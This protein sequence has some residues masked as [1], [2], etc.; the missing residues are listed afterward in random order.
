MSAH[1]VN[2]P[3]GSGGGNNSSRDVESLLA[4]FHDDD[5]FKYRA[6]TYTYLLLFPVSFVCNIGALVVFF[7]QSSRRS[8]A[9]CVVMMNLALSDGSFALTLPLR[10]AYYFRG[11]VWDFPDWLCRLC[12]YGF[13]VNL[14][15]SILFLTLLSMLRWLA[16]AR[17]LQHRTLATP[18]RS[19]LV[20]LGVWLFVAVASA[21]FLTNGVT[22][23]SGFRRCFEPSSP[24]SWGRVLILNYVAFALGFLLPFLTIIVC[25][26]R[27]VRRLTARSDLQLHGSSPSSAARRCSRRRSVHLVTMVTATFLLCFLPYHVIRS[28]HLH[29]V[30]GGWNCEVTVALQRAVVVT[31][32]LAASNSVVNPLLYYYSTRTFRDKLRDAQSSL[33]INRG[34]SIRSG[35]ALVRR[36]NTWTPGGS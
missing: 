18:T 32:C 20:C 22:N 16:V 28:L 27:I 6:Y 25:Y 14:Y 24:S 23:R 3:I 4:C 13:Y 9:S 7:L 11:G 30:C 34:G 26:S 31:L 19:L 36:R 17:P 21:P 10:L 12:V 8:S 29:A 15:T 35:L 33:L 5:A 2:T 1:L